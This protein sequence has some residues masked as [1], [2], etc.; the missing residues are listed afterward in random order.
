[1]LNDV[2]ER[3]VRTPSETLLDNPFLIQIVMMAVMKIILFKHV[4]IRNVPK[5][6][7]LVLISVVSIILNVV[8]VRTLEI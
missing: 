2:I 7:S 8:M 3:L 4:C 6:N 1:M 5:D